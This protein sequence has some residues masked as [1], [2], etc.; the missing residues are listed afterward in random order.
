MDASR[1]LDLAVPHFGLGHLT[2]MPQ[3]P[4][5]YKEPPH[6]FSHV[7]SDMEQTRE[8]AIIEFREL[9]KCQNAS[10]C[11]KMLSVVVPLIVGGITY[12]FTDEEQR[13][14]GVIVAATFA[15]IESFE[16]WRS[17]RDAFTSIDQFFANVVYTS[18]FLDQW[19]RNALKAS[20]RFF[21]GPATVWVLEIVQNYVLLLAFGRNTAWS[22]VG[23]N[24]NVGLYH[25]AIDLSMAYAWW[26]VSL[27]LELLYKPAVVP[28]ASLFAYRVD[29]LLLGILAVTLYFAA[30]GEI[31][32][33]FPPPSRKWP[34][35]QK[36]IAGIAMLDYRGPG[37]F[38][39]AILDFEAD[40]AIWWRLKF[41][42][43][44]GE[45][46]PAFWHGH[47]KVC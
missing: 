24:C 37:F 20:T 8:A 47:T 40:G 12:A 18:L 45:L 27:A 22:Y 38:P 11:A 42:F 43:P 41:D 17:D 13:A 44:N 2:E 25:G 5:Y 15:L 29:R 1:G 39:K 46:R 30:K 23:Q 16:Y 34:K 10:K 28:L 36:T 6:I 9:M 31:M 33:R 21:L 35:S 26:I 7:R 4:N 14:R 32:P 3:N 19:Q